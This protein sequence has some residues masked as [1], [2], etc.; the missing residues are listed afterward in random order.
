KKHFIGFFGPY[1]ILPTEGICLREPGNVK[2]LVNN[3]SKFEF[4]A[5]KYIDYHRFL[6]GSLRDFN[7]SCSCKISEK[8]IIIKINDIQIYT[9]LTSIFFSSHM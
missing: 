6:F 5:A 7:L 2:Y 4:F 8:I 9:I 3:V 1:Q